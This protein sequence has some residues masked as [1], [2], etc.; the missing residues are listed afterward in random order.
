MEWSN[1]LLSS[2]MLLELEVSR[3]RGQMSEFRSR[4]EKS[5][6]LSVNGDQSKVKCTL[7]LPNKGKLFATG[8][9]E[10]P[11]KL[12]SELAAKFAKEQKITISHK[13]MNLNREANRFYNEYQLL[14]SHSMRE[15]ASEKISA[16]YCLNSKN[17]KTVS[18]FLLQKRYTKGFQMKNLT[19]SK[20]Y[21]NSNVLFLRYLGEKARRYWIS[22]KRKTGCLLGYWLTLFLSINPQFSLLKEC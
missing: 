4:K 12:A 5:N 22:E 13:R 8:P 14:K 20:H 1:K 17:R 6:Q 9:L 11:A 19:I 7:F 2:N 21:K 18:C 3:K 10:K 16:A 15:E